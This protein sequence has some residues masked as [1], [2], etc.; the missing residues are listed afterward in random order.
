MNYLKVPPH[1]EIPSIRPTYISIGGVNIPPIRH[2]FRL[3]WNSDVLSIVCKRF[4]LQRE[5][6][7]DSASLDE[8]S[9]S[10][11]IGGISGTL[12]KLKGCSGVSGLLGRGILSGLHGVDSILVLDTGG[13]FGIS[14]SDARAIS[15][16]SSLHAGINSSDEGKRNN[17]SV[18]EIDAIAFKIYMSGSIIMLGGIIIS[19]LEA[20]RRRQYWWLAVGISCAALGFVIGVSGYPIARHLAP[21]DSLSENVGVQPIVVPELE[22]GNVQRQ[23]FVADLVE[24]AHNAAL[25]ERPEALDC[26]RMNRADDMLTLGMVNRLMREPILQSV[27]ARIGVSAKQA[28]ACGDGFANEARERRA[29]SL[30]DDARDDVPLAPD[31]ADDGG[32]A[33]VP[34]SA[35]SAFL[36]PMPIAVFAADVGFVDFDDTA[37]LL[38]V[39]DEG[40][41]D[42]MA[43][44]PSSLVRTKAHITVD[45]KSRHSP[46]ADKHQVNNSIPVFERLVCVLEYR[47][48]QVREAIASLRS[49]RVAL[50][51]PSHSRD[52][53]N[54]RLAAARAANAFRPAASYQ[55]P[56]TVVFGLKQLVELCCGQLMNGFDVGHG[57]IS[58]ECGGTVA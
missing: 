33:S 42:F 36:I 51:M 44:K 35:R 57:G 26:V 17:R 2:F 46:F 18:N 29:V 39:F 43:H 58:V 4:N 41:A 1:R 13:D 52:C 20:G 31:C 8:S 55:I 11:F 10:R 37:K 12:R 47:S 7:L 24:A 27:I 34:A 22:F 54:L 50:P 56:D 48:S 19:G 14:N 38:N 9:L 40:D 30:G 49:A 5:I 6:G 23:I 15:K 45:L 3:V 32:L 53:A 21:F 16:A 25:N 28:D